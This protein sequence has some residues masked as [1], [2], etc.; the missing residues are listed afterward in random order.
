VHAVQPPHVCRVDHHQH[1]ADVAC[2]HGGSLDRLD[3]AVAEDVAQPR[4]REQVRHQV[5]RERPPLQQQ[6]LRPSGGDAADARDGGE[7]D[8][9]GAED[10]ADAED[11][12]VA[13][14]TLVHVPV[15]L[16]C[17]QHR[18]ER[19]DCVDDH[20][21]RRTT[22]RHEGGSRDV[23]AHVPAH[24][25]RLQAHDEVAVGHNGDGDKGI[26]ESNKLDC[27]APPL[28]VDVVQA[29]V[30]PAVQ[31]AGGAAAAAERVG[32]AD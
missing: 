30:L 18:L 32:G 20:L 8:H 25:Q 19:R 31:R 12:V 5:A 9:A 16:L 27:H 23:L 28:A 13:V 7:G 21:W 29:E 14:V 1:V 15:V 10:G 3:A 11:R 24:A 17:R 22:E 6:R 2:E 26:H 4:D